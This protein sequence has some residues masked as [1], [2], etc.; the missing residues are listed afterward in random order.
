MKEKIKTFFKNGGWS[1]IASIISFVT[2]LYW[3]VSNAL[4]KDM[5]G[6]VASVFVFLPW[7]LLFWNRYEFIQEKNMLIKVCLRLARIANEATAGLKRY[8]DIY[9][10]QTPEEEKSKQ[11][12]NNGKSE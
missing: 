10:E 8:Q 5:V 4:E 2:M 6:L 7:T 1:L 11:P 3:A 12:K 9:G